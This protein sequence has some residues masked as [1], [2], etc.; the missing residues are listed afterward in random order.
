VHQQKSDLL[1]ELVR[2]ARQDVRRATQEL[3]EDETR[4]DRLKARR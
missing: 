3:T 2:S 1:H 4:L